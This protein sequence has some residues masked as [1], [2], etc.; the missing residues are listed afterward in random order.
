MKAIV[1]DRYG[2][3]A[4][5]LADLA[6]PVPGPEEILVRVRAAGVDTGVHHVVTGTPYLIRVLGYGLRGPKARVPG[7][8]AAGTVEAVGAR[9]SRFKPGDEVFGSDGG[10]FA[11]YAAV[12]AERFAHMPTG[13]SFEEAAALPNSGVTALQA[14]RGRVVAGG[15]VLVIGAGG[16]VGT[17]AV[18]L[19]R[20][21]GGRVTGVC[22]PGKAELVAGLGAEVV[23]YTKQEI[24]GRY[25]L[26]VDTA[27]NR[28]VLALRRLLTARGVLVIVGG[29]GGGRLIGGIQRNLWAALTSAVSS[30]KLTAFITRMNAAD[31]DTLRAHVEAGEVAPVIGRTHD[32]ADAAAALGHIA[33]GHATGKVVLTVG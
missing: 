29:D 31:L 27:G 4:L 26:I 14:V 11:E 30:Q 21:A 13:L 17:F 28:R 24:T 2:I 16:G 19:A 5:Q 18:Q 12:K 9:V 32:L 15:R 25:D 20:A 22:G 33:T 3:D 7:L 1:Q 10:T 23:D 8:D 6:R